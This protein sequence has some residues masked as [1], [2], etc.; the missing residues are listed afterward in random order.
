MPIILKST[1]PLPYKRTNGGFTFIEVLISMAILAIGFAGLNAMETLAMRKN[2]D[3]FL[4]AQAVLQAREMSDRMHA[5]PL[6]VKNGDYGNNDLLP[7]VIS[8]GGANPPT[9]NCITATCLVVADPDA[10]AT[11][12]ADFDAD[13]WLFATALLLPS[14]AGNV[15]VDP[16]FG[17]VDSDGN[18]LF[19]G[20]FT[21]TIS[22]NEVVNGNESTAKSFAFEF[23]TLPPFEN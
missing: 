20:L 2:N 13:E 1:Q 5:N 9:P 4:R 19:N 17:T 22:W 14:G 10:S 23:T 16:S 21:I 6:G 7:K 18:S 8:G 12:I 15:T 11:K 3:S